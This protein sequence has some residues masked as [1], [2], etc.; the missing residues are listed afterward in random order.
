MQNCFIFDFDH[1]LIKNHKSK[2]RTQMCNE[3]LEGKGSFIKNIDESQ[4]HTL[5]VIQILLP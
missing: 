3:N 5:H 4:S 2:K 1:P